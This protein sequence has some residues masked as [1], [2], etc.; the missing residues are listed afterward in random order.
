MSTT[1]TAMHWGVYEVEQRAGAKPLLKPFRHDPA[2][3]P[4]GLSILA[5]GT[6]RLRIRRPAVRRGWLERG[7]AGHNGEGRG[8]DDFIEIDWA[9]ASK[10]VA[11]EVSRVKVAHGNSAIFGGSY[12]WSSAGRFHHAQS[13]VHRFLNAV[14]GYVR[15]VDTYSLGAGRAILPHI[16][17]PMDQLMQTHTGWD[18]MEAH[19]ELFVAFGGVPAKNAQVSSGGAAE[20]RVPGAIARMA[21]RGVRFVN[22]SPIRDNLV[23]EGAVEWIAIRPNTD[24]ALMLAIA[25]ELIV[26]D[27]HDK[28]FLSKYC[29]GFEHFADYVTGR[30]DGVAKSPGWAEHITEVPAATIAQLA[31]DMAASRTMLNVA[32]SL[33]RAHH[34]ENAFWMTV[35]LAAMLGQ[36][37]LAGGG[38]GL[39]Y[40]ATNLMGSGHPR[41]SGPT[42][43]QGTNAVRDFIP[44]ARIANMLERP[45]DAFTYL[46]G[47]YAYPDIRLIYWAGGNPFHHHQDLHRLSRAWRKKPETIVV[48]E[49]YWNANAKMADIVLPAT[50]TL[51]RD[52]I[53]YA[54]RER[55]MI[56]MKRAVPPIADARDDYDIFS[57]IAEVTGARDAFTEGRTSRQWLELL[58]EEGRGKARAAGVTLPAFD[59]F[60]ERGFVELRGSNEPVI[61]LDAFRNDPDAGKLATP[62]GR[63][64]VFS[65]RIA[66]FGLPNQPGHACWNEPAEWLG[67]DKAASFP[68]HLLT[69]QPDTRLHSQL[70]HSPYS[71]AAKVAGR[72]PLTLNPIDAARRNIADGDLVRVFNNRGQLLAGAIVSNVVRPGVLRLSTGAWVAPEELGSPDIL[73]TNGNANVLTL[74]IGASPLT[75]GCSAHT[76]LV[77]VERYVGDPP[78]I[79]A[80]RIPALSQGAGSDES[81]ST[82]RA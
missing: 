18:V 59:E 22:V 35:T 13:Q 32:W 79:R 34:G 1:F 2:P 3:N 38:F 76:C 30:S 19:T 29:T 74:D 4:I 11:S 12:G 51:E 21:R 43:P 61:L 55:F 28:A 65:S 33:Q 80:Y 64:E 7:A 81:P 24:V 52:D 39:G 5:D 42:L 37:G 45:G 47:S 77:E 57:E 8:R 17:A 63:I 60:W 16:V 68:L 48:H 36:I 46:G 70:D 82:R 66:G 27:L 78:E 58:Y 71:Q 69:D 15:H 20:H 75:Q 31:R 54:N 9:E 49:Q 14:G 25:H 10:L 73:E 67:S 23:A 72:Q 26:A 53:G 41:F 6:E 62:S 44:V 56:A 50:T 40:G